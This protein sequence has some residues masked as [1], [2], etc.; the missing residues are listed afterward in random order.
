MGVGGA[1]RGWGDGFLDRHS[2][3]P[4]SRGTLRVITGHR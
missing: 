4:A 3:H 1:P 2:G